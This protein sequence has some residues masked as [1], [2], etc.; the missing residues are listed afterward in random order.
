M[1][2]GASAGIGLQLTHRLA[3]GLKMKVAGCARNKDK[4]ME[5]QAAVEAAGGAFLPVQCDVRDSAS[6]EAMFDQ[7]AAKWGGV[8]VMINN[9]GM[10]RE[11]G[12][13]TG[14]PEGWREMFEV[15]VFALAQCSRLAVA[16]MRAR[17]VEGMV[18]NIS[19]MSAHRV[20]GASSGFYAATKHAVRAL[21]ETLRL[22]VLAQEEADAALPPVRVSQISP[23]LVETEFALRYLGE[24]RG[25]AL[26]ESA[27]DRKLLADD[28]VDAAV[29]ALSSPA[30]AQVNDILLRPAKQL[31]Y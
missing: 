25:T 17:S 15:N 22:E 28:V 1:I 26:Y 18:M 7:V 12:V 21:T 11:G 5:V 19:S 13:L 14:T 16:S 10:A 30:R 3:A 8:D 2:T 9:A 6:V 24:E 23:G 27:G 29:Y 20:A 31:M 4:L